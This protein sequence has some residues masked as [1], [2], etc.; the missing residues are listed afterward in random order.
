MQ[1]KNRPY[2]EGKVFFLDIS[3]YR[4]QTFFVLWCKVDPVL[5]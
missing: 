5:G 2:A 3:F 1:E 4:T